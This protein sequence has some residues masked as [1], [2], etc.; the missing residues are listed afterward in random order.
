MYHNLLFH[1]SFFDHVIPQTYH[2][3]GSIISAGIR[4]LSLLQVVS[5]IYAE[6][7]SACWQAWTA[8]QDEFGAQEKAHQNA[9]FRKSFRRMLFSKTRIRLMASFMICLTLSFVRSNVC[10][11]SLR[12]MGAESFRP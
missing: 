9:I 6:Q 5:D 1:R 2:L 10:P 11:I 7:F 4:C 12:V 3:C 8:E